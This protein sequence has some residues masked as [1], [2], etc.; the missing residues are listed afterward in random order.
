MAT[1]EFNDAG[2]TGRTVRG[3]APDTLN[4]PGNLWIAG[5]GESYQA[6]NVPPGNPGYATNSGASTS[7]VYELGESNIIADALMRFAD[8]TSGGHAGVVF[9]YVDGN[10]YWVFGGNGA[11]GYKCWLVNGGGYTTIKESTYTYNSTDGNLFAVERTGSGTVL[12]KIDGTTVHTE[13]TNAATHATATKHGYGDLNLGSSK[14]QHYRVR[15][16]T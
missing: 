11:G 15:L 1:E 6:G 9:N 10:N 4:T 16:G 12:L 14:A 5:R 8:A 2:G 3:T 7:N 13:T